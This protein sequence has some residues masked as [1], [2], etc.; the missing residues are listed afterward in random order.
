M[1][2]RK[3]RKKRAPLSSE[4]R[5]LRRELFKRLDGVMLRDSDRLERRIRSA[6]TAAACSA[7]ATDLETAE[8]RL[9]L[10]KASIPTISYPADLPIT[11]RLDDV[12]D[13]LSKHQV[14]VVAGETGSGKTTQLPKL[15]M[16]LGLGQRGL[17][18]HTQPRRIAARSVAERIAEELGSS[19][20]DLVGY[21]V[22]FTDEVSENTAV[23]V[24]TDGILLAEIRHDRLLRNYDTIIIDEAHERSL[25]IDFLL[26][27]LKRILPERPDL[28]I[29]ITSATIETHRFAEHFAVGGKPAPIIEV[30]G[31]TYPVEIRYRPGEEEQDPLDVFI[32]AVFE[33]YTESHVT[34]GD[35]LAFFPGE[36]EIH[37]AADALHKSEFKTLEV[38][39][40]YGRLSAADQHRVFSPSGKQRIILAT[41]VAETSLT[42]PGIRYVIDTGTARISHYSNRTKIQRLPIEE[43]SQAS[44]KQRAGRCGRL[45][46]G[47]AVRLYTEEDFK[48]RPLYTEPEILR[49]NLAS[50][51]LQMAD[52]GFGSI[53][54]FPFL[55]CPDF[56]SVKD[57]IQVLTELGALRKDMTLTQ[58]G[59]LMARIP[60]DPRLSR[61]LIEA[62]RRNVLGSVLVIVAALSIRDIRERP[63][64]KE[65]AADAKHARFRNPE[66]DFM[67][68]IQL[69]NYLGEQN[70]ALSRSQFRKLCRED[71][72]HW[73]RYWEW[74]D[75]ISQLTDI[76]RQL[77]WKWEPHRI[78][79]GV[80]EDR[81]HQALL[82]GLLSNIGVRIGET[83][84]YQGTRGKRFSI[85]PASGILRRTSILMAYEIVET[86]RVWGRTLAAVDP[87]WVEKAAGNA[88]SRRYAEPHWS[89]S[90][91]EV[92]AYESTSLWGVPL[93]SDRLVSYRRVDPE[94]SRRTFLINALVHNDWKYDYS[95]IKENQR[96]IENLEA[97]EEKAR[98]RG[99]VA[100]E[101]AIADLYEKRIPSSVMSATDFAQWWK[102]CSVGERQALVLEE[103][104]IRAASSIGEDSLLFPDEMHGFDLSYSFLPGSEDDGIAVQIPLPEL[105]QFD[106][107]LFSWLVPGM[108]HELV[109]TA[110]RALPK[111]YRKQLIPLPD[112]AQKIV[113]TLPDKPTG[114]FAEALS[115]CVNSLAG[116]SIPTHEFAHLDLPD[117]LRMRFVAVDRRGKPVD[118]DRDFAALLSRQSSKSATAVKATFQ[119]SKAE[120]FSSWDESVGSI[121]KEVTAGNVIG[122][123]ALARQKKGWNIDTFTTRQEAYSAQLSAILQLLED[124]LPGP[125]RQLF[126]GISQPAQLA[127]RG[128]PGG[129]PALR[130]DCHKCAIRDVVILEGGPTWD[131]EKFAELREVVREK[132][133]AR[134]RA[135]ALLCAQAVLARLNV[136]AVIP[137]AEGVPSEIAEQVDWLTSPGF[138]TRHGAIRIRH[139][140][141]YLKAALSRFE[142]ASVVDGVWVDEDS[143]P[144][145]AFYTVEDALWDKVGAPSVDEPLKVKKVRWLL[146]EFKVSVF[147]QQLG[148]AEKVSEKR[149]LKEIEELG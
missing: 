103:S 13:A 110:L 138:V 108:R 123:P 17:I 2:E 27:Y 125:R 91:G 50:V 24:M 124:E 149:L 58:T 9:A 62:D 140:P 79:G 131:Y 5:A 114:S 36:R 113:D 34:G 145:N 139:I 4:V 60:V 141:R 101:E 90:R 35:I 19:V 115:N 121:P 31:R 32:D 7:I 68:F 45:S 99:L 14:V 88:L 109:M 69:W 16:E 120:E 83:R 47:I 93:V 25:N 38:L 107:R 15:C 85:F 54:D 94:Y 42:V 80:P 72:L 64:D 143:V 43:V 135:I 41:N 130:E 136:L 128:Y 127:L 71:Y 73:L 63:A 18:G 30:S 78:E 11:D 129:D 98:Q 142:K 86:S 33:L 96:T 39:P 28:H 112:T 111:G 23:K 37:D 118:S 132:L 82:S 74:R 104:D 8:L 77:G 95:F 119:I 147:G 6:R 97:F 12:R 59:R 20:G 75:L 55:D 81:I 89:S 67:S 65:E 117:H 44:A 21:T 76:C 10:R 102:K 48:L 46:D 122:F 57:G 53:E 92:L 66:S 100:D 40:L 49:T 105:P 148:T 70:K 87:E 51:I 137:E 52:L 1:A 126:N 144:V 26:G 84:E 3:N 116:V 134:E 61:M 133:G 106:P 56:S 146:E 29:I 22:R